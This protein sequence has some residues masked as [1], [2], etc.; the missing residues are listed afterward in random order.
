MSGVTESRALIVTAVVGAAL[1]WFVKVNFPNSYAS[2]TP[3]RR[4]QFFA[5]PKKD[6]KT[7]LT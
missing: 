6:R 1:F 7:G 5:S 2:F 4:E 3:I